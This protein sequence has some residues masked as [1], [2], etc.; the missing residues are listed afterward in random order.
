MM[1]LQLADSIQLLCEISVSASTLLESTQAL[2]DNFSIFS[3]LIKLVL[4]AF[5]LLSN[6]IFKFSCSS[7]CDVTLFEIVIYIF[8]HGHYIDSNGG[9]S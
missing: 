8:E 4:L 7:L 9:G 3:S 2:S 6:E 5:R 1:P